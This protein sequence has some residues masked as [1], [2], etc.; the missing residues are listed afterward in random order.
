LLSRK[1]TASV[2][3]QG[4]RFARCADGD[5]LL[6]TEQ[7]DFGPEQAPK[8]GRASDRKQDAGLLPGA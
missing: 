3:K 7:D 5:K 1:W 8:V 4:K 6:D 2:P